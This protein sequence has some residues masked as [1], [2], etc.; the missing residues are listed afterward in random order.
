MKKLN[1]NWRNFW[2]AMFVLS[3]SVLALLMLTT[4]PTGTRADERRADDPHDDEEPF[5][6]IRA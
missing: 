2:G 5:H 6:G 1:F 4:S 3:S